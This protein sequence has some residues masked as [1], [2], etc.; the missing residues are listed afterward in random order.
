MTQGE[1]IRSIERYFAGERKGAKVGFALTASFVAIALSALSLDT[2]FASGVAIVF[3]LFSPLLAF[4]VGFVY[5]RAPKD[6]LR[7]THFAIKGTKGLEGDE[8]PRMKKVV[9]NFHIYRIG[10]IGMV[11]L[12]AILLLVNGESFLGGIGVALS[13]LGVVFLVFDGYA[14]RRAKRYLAALEAFSSSIHS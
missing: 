1:L 14:D 5:L 11:L 12:G 3:A 10:E 8:I 6:I 4:I 13:L 9:R 7:V 2:S